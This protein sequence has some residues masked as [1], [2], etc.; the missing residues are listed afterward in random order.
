MA[1]KQDLMALL[2]EAGFRGQ[3]LA[4]AYAIALAESGGRARAHNPNA[5]TGDNSYG[6]F[7]INMLGKMG[8]ARLK[9]YGLSSNEDLF[10]PLTNAKVAYKMSHGG[11]NFQPWT[12]FTSGK[13]KDFLGQSGAQVSGGGSQTTGGGDQVAST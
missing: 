11:T 6:L 1:S 3:G 12:T 2:K 7:Q 8:P 5:S 4:N 10:D 9:Q 13:Y